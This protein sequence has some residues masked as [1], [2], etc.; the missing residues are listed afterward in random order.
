MACYIN[1]AFEDENLEIELDAPGLLVMAN[2][3]PDTN[4]SQFFITLAACPHLNGKHT[5]FGKVV[6]GLPVI[7]AKLAEVPTDGKDRPLTP[8]FISHCG[9][10]ELRKKEPVRE[11]SASVSE[12]S[13]D[14]RERKRKRKAE[15]RDKRD[16][17]EKRKKKQRSATPEPTEE[18]LA[19]ARRQKEMAEEEDRRME[20]EKRR[21]DAERKQELEKIRDR[22]GGD[23]GNGVVLK[24]RGAMKYR[25][26]GSGMRG[27]D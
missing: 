3:G 21:A 20:E 22:L 10:L 12:V 4:S 5:V 14:E 18:A 11:R 13:D 16:R 17:K 23:R 26:G 25:E 1:A 24:G 2:R 7:E 19:A 27:W 9:E 6:A 15:K 8:V